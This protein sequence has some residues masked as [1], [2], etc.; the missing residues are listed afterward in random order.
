[1]RYDVH[2]MYI[3]LKFLLCI[4]YISAERIY[5]VIKLFIINKDF[6]FTIFCQPPYA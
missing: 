2:M 3:V 6:V 1:M 5:F 4:M